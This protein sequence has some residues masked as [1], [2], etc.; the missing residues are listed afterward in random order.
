MDIEVW[1]WYETQWFE[2]VQELG[3]DMRLTKKRGEANSLGKKLGIAMF[4][5]LS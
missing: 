2:V 3:D 5:I 4:R 1:R